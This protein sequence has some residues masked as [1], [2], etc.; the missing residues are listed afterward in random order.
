[1]K[2][3]VG[4]GFLMAA[5]FLCA[6]IAVAQETEIEIR[7]GVVL[8]VNGNELMFRGPE[9][10]RTVTVPD[11]F[12]FD[13]GGRQLSVHQLEPGMRLTA[14]IKTTT[15]PV[16]MTVTVR[17]D[18]PVAVDQTLYTDIDT[19]LSIVLEVINVDEDTL[20]YSYLDLPD[21][22]SIGGVEPDI[23]YTPNSGF[24]GSDSFVFQVTD[25]EY[26]D[27][28]TISIIVIEPGDFECYLPLI[29]H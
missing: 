21:N 26:T 29:I 23:V 14:V 22:G 10:V 12:R 2:G 5:L 3:K 19:P 16:T 9:G 17:N 18:P 28:A 13:M 20:L 24:V 27:S 6:G 7:N 4:T 8:A 11:D 25:G 1:M 15:R